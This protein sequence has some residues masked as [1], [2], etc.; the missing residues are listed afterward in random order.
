M[1][2]TPPMSKPSAWSWTT[3]KD[4]VVIILSVSAITISIVAIVN[5]RNY[6]N[7]FAIFPIDLS[8]TSLTENGLPVTRGG[9]GATDFDDSPRFLKANG[10]DPF[11]TADLTLTAAEGGTGFEDYDEGQILI[12]CPDGTLAQRFLHFR[13]GLAGVAGGN[14]SCS[15]SI[16]LANLYTVFEQYHFTERYTSGASDPGDS[17]AGFNNRSLNTVVVDGGSGISLDTGTGVMT[18]LTGTCKFSIYAPV[19]A[20]GEHFV[21]LYG[22]TTATEYARGMFSFADTGVQTVSIVEGFIS[23]TEDEEDL[24]VQSWTELSVVSG[25]GITNATVNPRVYTSA[26]FECHDTQQRQ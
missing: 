24:V 13:D 20:A 3:I 26:Y 17:V 19:Y 16:G 12:G 21:R 10:E 25:L 15:F 8:N 22:L 9:T 6:P 11:N 2:D 1:L 7:P 14:G 5:S 18:M 23:I 4:M